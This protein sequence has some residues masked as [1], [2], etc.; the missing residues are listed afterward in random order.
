[1]RG[2]SEGSEFFNPN[3]GRGKP[4]PEGLDRELITR[5]VPGDDGIG[6]DGGYEIK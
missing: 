6:R 1:V 3:C 5:E 2:K 4:P